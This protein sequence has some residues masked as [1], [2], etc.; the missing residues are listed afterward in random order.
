MF[1]PPRKPGSYPVG[2]LG[3]RWSLPGTRSKGDHHVRNVERVVW[4]FDAVLLVASA[5][6]KGT[7][8]TFRQLADPEL[9]PRFDLCELIDIESGKVAAESSHSRE[10]V[11]ELACV[12][13][14]SS[15]RCP[16]SGGDMYTDVA[17]YSEALS[18]VGIASWLEETHAGLEAARY[19][20]DTAAHQ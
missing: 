20:L 12:A 7:L 19:V 15:P 10:V 1:P 6:I 2:R 11:R 16:Q 5:A 9:P 14:S 8:G 4:R 3:K 17:T 13:L 18:E